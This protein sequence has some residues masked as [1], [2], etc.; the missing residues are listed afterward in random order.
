MVRIVKQPPD[1][2]RSVC[3]PATPGRASHAH[4][5]NMPQSHEDL[6]KNAVRDDW[7]MGLKTVAGYVVVVV[8][9]FGLIYLGR[10]L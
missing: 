4:R 1:R 2:V 7:L 10:T 3:K 6:R 5:L 8:A 9:I